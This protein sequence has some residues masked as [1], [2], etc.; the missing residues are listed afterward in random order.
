MVYKKDKEK[1]AKNYLVADFNESIMSFNESL[2]F[3]DSY[4][5]SFNDSL[6]IISETMMMMMMMTKI[7]IR[8][9][10][11]QSQRSIRHVSFGKRF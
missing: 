9:R 3:D 1:S 2:I 11:N 7:M 8:S 5:D 10:S 4:N 6:Q